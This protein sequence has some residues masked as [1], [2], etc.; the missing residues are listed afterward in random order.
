MRIPI[1]I[2]SSLSGDEDDCEVVP[3]QVE[4]NVGR[5]TRRETAFLGTQNNPISTTYTNPELK[6]YFREFKLLF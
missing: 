4:P 2:S 1:T 3:Q 6:R 5:T